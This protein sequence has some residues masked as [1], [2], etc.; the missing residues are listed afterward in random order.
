MTTDQEQAPPG[1]TAV[2][3]RNVYKIFGGNEEGALSRALT[4]T[5]KEA[6]QELHGAVL[7]LAGVSF[8]VQRG[9]LFVVMGLSGCGKSTLVRCINR[10]IEPS[11][12]ECLAGRAGSHRDE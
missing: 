4:G 9:E 6:I 7:A 10:L 2:S 1:E 12:G 3:V 11:A 8:D 5:S